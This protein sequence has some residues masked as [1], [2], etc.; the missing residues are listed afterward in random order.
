MADRVTQLQEAVNQASF[1]P[2]KYVM[3]IGF[4]YPQ[5]GEY[6][7]NSIGILQAN[8]ESPQQNG[9]CVCVEVSALNVLKCCT[10]AG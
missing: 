1:F 3:C 10:L 2:C 7:C 8:T 9:M 6:F 4:M 5:L